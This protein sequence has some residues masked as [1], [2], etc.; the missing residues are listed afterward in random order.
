MIIIIIYIYDLRSSIYYYCMCHFVCQL[1]FAALYDDYT[2]TSPFEVTFSPDSFGLVTTQSFS[3]ILGRDDT[4]IEG[5]HSFNVLLQSIPAQFMDNV[6]LDSTP[7]TVTIIDGDGK[8]IM[9]H[10]N[11]KEYFLVH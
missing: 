3:G 5:P 2:V 11:Y 7:Q 6:M 4:S 9:H 1:L 10:S 8:C